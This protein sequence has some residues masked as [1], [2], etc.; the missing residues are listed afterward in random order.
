MTSPVVE[1]EVAAQLAEF[2]DRQRFVDNT[3]P[4][5]HVEAQKDTM[6]HL[7]ERAV[8]ESYKSTPASDTE[9]GRAAINRQPDTPD[10][11]HQTTDATAL[12]HKAQTEP[13]SAAS[14]TQRR[15]QPTIKESVKLLPETSEITTF[16]LERSGIVCSDTETSVSKAMAEKVVGQHIVQYANTEGQE[17][18]KTAAVEIDSI[19]SN[20]ISQKVT[21]ETGSPLA[22]SMMEMKVPPENIAGVVTD[23]TMKNVWQGNPVSEEKTVM[24]VQTVVAQ[25]D[26]E[27]AS[28]SAQFVQNS[29]GNPVLSQHTVSRSTNIMESSP[30]QLGNVLQDSEMSDMS[31]RTSISPGLNAT[32]PEMERLTPEHNIP[33]NEN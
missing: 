25:A 20:R 27:R 14:D 22:K 16:G 19:K 4:A 15:Q 26:G 30:V 8:V 28:D 32:T 31:D 10:V 6:Y 3:I 7:Y 23:E 9:A 12:Q 2:A 1:R 17:G 24:A 11:T 5:A 18:N 13:S 29:T 33:P 21:H